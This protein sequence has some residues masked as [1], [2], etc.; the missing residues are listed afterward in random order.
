VVKPGARS[1]PTATMSF[2]DHLEELRM[3]LILAIIG[4][5][6][7][8]VVAFVFGRPLLE[9]LLLPAQRA[10]SKAG[11]N[12]EFQMVGPL[13]GFTT[14]MRVSMIAAV[15]VGAPWI[16]Y[17]IWRFVAPGLHAH[18]RR[19]V[20]LLLPMSAVL[21]ALGGV[22]LYLVMLP[23]VMAF[24]ISFGSTIS[25]RPVPEAPLPQDVVLPSVP[26]LEADPVNP[27]RGEMWM[28]SHPWRLRVNVAPEGAPKDVV[29]VVLQRETGVRPDYRLSEYLNLVLGLAL[30]FAVGFQTPVIVLLLGWMGIVDRAFLVSKRKYALLL[31]FVVGA[32]LTPA[33]PA[34]MFVL[35]VPLYALYELGVLMLR[36]LTPERVA[37]GLSREPPDAGDE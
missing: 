19:F 15:V 2:G 30:G 22:V 17:Q 5:L 28:L 18:E 9:F 32:V 24:F 29:G 26:L 11:Q 36:F 14:Y 31:A 25:H 35:A 16:V 37:R 20:H 1:D 21:T 27:A 34:S 3:R 6:P 10:L 4:L 13:E 8:A 33:D 12:P 7:L 23:V